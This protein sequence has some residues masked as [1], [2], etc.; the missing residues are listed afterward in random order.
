[1]SKN[2]LI[3]GG[4]R[5]ILPVIE[6]AK[7]LGCKV[8]TCDYLP[9]N[10]AHRYSD[11]YVNASIVDKDAVLQAA[12]Q[13]KADGIMSFAADPGVISAAYAA[14]KMGLPFQGSYESVSILQNKDRFRRFLSQHIFNCPFSY[15]LATLSDVE[16]IKDKIHFPVIVKPVDSAG[17]KGVTKVES[18]DELDAAVEHAFHFSLGHRCIVEQFIE[19][20]GDSSDADGFL[21]DGEAACISF[22][23]QLFDPAADNPYV[24]AAYRMPASMPEHFRNELKSEI[25]RLAKLLDLRSGLFNIETRVGTDGKPYIMEMSPRGGGNRLSEMLKYASGVDLIKASIQ[26]SLG[27][28]VTDIGEPQYDGIWYQEMLH[29]CRGGVFQGIEYSEGFKESHVVDEQLWIK[30]GTKVEAFTGANHAF[31]SIIMRFSKRECNGDPEAVISSNV[32]VRVA[33]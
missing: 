26:A 11:E 22:T 24:P 28:R 14:E 13:V 12:Q 10:I 6:S 25:N 20:L 4:S 29:S 16:A 27:M 19:K 15:S 31:G 8:I 7:K 18:L 33:S 17:S 3:L 23:S 1:M 9:D 30:P 32:T 5:Y 21:V 2:L